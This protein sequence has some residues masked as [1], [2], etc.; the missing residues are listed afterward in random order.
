M[1]AQNFHSPQMLRSGQASLTATR[2]RLDKAVVFHFAGHAIASARQTGLLL[3]DAA[4]TY[5]SMKRVDLS[6]MRLAVLS[7]CD[8]L[9]D[10]DNGN[11]DPDSLVRLFVSA[12]VPHF[13]ASRWSVDSQATRG[14]MNVFYAELL[15]G[16]TVTAA[17]YQSRTWLRAQSGRQHPYYWAAF[18]Q[19]GIN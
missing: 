16:K 11:Y 17:L 12:G 6:R 15:Q 9:G 3:S 10:I 1:V 8:T 7:G 14:L 18:T 13:V 19:F 5:E 2:S 4:L